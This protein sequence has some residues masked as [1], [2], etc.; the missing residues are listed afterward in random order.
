MVL[1]DGEVP[2]DLVQREGAEAVLHGEDG[3]GSRKTRIA[4]NLRA[5]EDDADKVPLRPFLNLFPDFLLLPCLCAGRELRVCILICR[6]G[7]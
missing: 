5:L 6:Y 7:S 3:T 2:K 4:N 1:V